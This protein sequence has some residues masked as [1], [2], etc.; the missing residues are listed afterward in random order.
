EFVDPSLQQARLMLLWRV[1]GLA[2]VE[3]TYALDVL[4]D[5]LSQGR[6]ARLVQDLREERGLVLGVGANNVTYQHQGL[7]CLSANLMSENIPV[8]E[9]AMLD[10]IQ[11][12]QNDL[13]PVAE[14]EKV[15]TQAANQFIFGNETPSDRANLYGY[16]QALLG[17][18]RPAFDYAEKVR[19]LTPEDLQRAAQTYLP[20][21]AYGAVVVRPS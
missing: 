11:R 4:A 17:D 5:I 19:S 12:L 1:P 10:H 20:T 21:N 9:Q 18:L 7:F 2:L 15:C 14:L 8:V 3:H 6:T 13:V 16:Y